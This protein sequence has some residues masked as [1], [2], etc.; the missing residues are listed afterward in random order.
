MTRVL[1]PSI[2]SLLFQHGFGGHPFQK[3]SLFSS[4]ESG[5]LCD[6]R[7]PTEW[8]RS[9]PCASSEPDSWRPS[10]LAYCAHSWAL[11]CPERK[12]GYLLE[13]ETPHGI[14]TSSWRQSPPGAGGPQL[15]C[16]GTAAVWAST[17]EP[18]RHPLGLAQISTATQRTDSAAK[19][20]C[21]WLYATEACG[22]MAR[23]GQSI[24]DTV[25]DYFFR[26]VSGI[27]FYSRNPCLDDDTW[28]WPQWLCHSTI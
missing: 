15:T 12:L 26:T 22:R 20:Q 28:L 9:D 5:Q 2:Y 4:F 8:S 6:S 14:E 7:W 19:N 11:S 3:W 18:S 13:G 10:V 16:Q 17:P 24:T 25:N 21:L 27:F 23:L 1:Y